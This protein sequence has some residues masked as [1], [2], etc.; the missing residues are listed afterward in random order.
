MAGKQYCRRIAIPAAPGPHSLVPG[1]WPWDCTPSLLFYHIRYP[2]TVSTRSRLVLKKQSDH[3]SLT[4][5]P[6]GE[7]RM[8]IP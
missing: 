1:P 8:G 4:L 7:H 6:G 3:G 5:G 2:I